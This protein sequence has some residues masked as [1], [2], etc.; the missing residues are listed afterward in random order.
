MKMAAA[1]PDA[2]SNR[3]GLEQLTKSLV[4]EPDK[5]IMAVV[6]LDSSVTTVDHIKHTRTPTVR[7]V[8]IEP[9]V[10]RGMRREAAELITRAYAARTSEQLELPLG[11][12]DQSDPPPVQD[13]LRYGSGLHTS[14]PFGE[15]ES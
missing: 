13:L 9:M 4:E 12:L 14:S 15:D 5:P 1:L 3:N 2:D 7:I 6:L 10:T 11:I 8:H